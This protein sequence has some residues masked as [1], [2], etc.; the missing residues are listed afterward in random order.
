MS[1]FIFLSTFTAKVGSGAAPSA[2]EVKF[3]T[4][5][6]TPTTQPFDVK[7]QPEIKLNG[8]EGVM[9]NGEM[10]WMCGRRLHAA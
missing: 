10:R 7:I 4:H 9:R 6:A 2:I 1:S 5:I 3:E 8:G